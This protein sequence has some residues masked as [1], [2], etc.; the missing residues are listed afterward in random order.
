L[1]S[2]AGG[3]ST[4]GGY[5]DPIQQ[6]DGHSCY[7]HWSTLER[8]AS[9]PAPCLGDA[10]AN[11]IRRQRGPPTQQVIAIMTPNPEFERTRI[12]VAGI[13]SNGFGMRASSAAPLN[14]TLDRSENVHAAAQVQ[15]VLLV[16]GGLSK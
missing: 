6:K 13:A 5:V 7:G 11:N 4:R 3:T 2:N 1:S 12:G 10:R 16:G 15:S 9:I 8:C 14:A